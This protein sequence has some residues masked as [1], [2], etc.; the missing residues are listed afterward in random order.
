MIYLHNSNQDGLVFCLKY[1]V[2]AE[3]RHQNFWAVYYHNFL[4][5]NM[6]VWITLKV[7]TYFVQMMIFY[8]YGW[9]GKQIFDHCI[10]FMARSQKQLRW[11]G[12]WQNLYYLKLW[13]GSTTVFLSP[14]R[15]NWSIRKIDEGDFLRDAPEHS[16]RKALTPNFS[17]LYFNGFMG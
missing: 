12:S 13:Y 14:K 1:K 9:N 8:K 4:C 17:D 6:I 2:R 16:G 7:C 5:F 11:M 15:R 10:S 3:S